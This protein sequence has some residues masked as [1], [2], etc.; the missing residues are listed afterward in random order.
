MIPLTEILSSI[1]LKI[2]K[3][4]LAKKKKI[5]SCNSIDSIEQNQDLK[6]KVKNTLDFYANDSK[7]KGMSSLYNRSNKWGICR[8]I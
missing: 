2:N 5:P 4:K 8:L 1:K 3:A 7:F 6:D